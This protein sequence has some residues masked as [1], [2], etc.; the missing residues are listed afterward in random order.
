MNETLRPSTLGEILDRTA[1]LYRRNF[2]LFAGTAALPV[3]AMLAIGVVAGALFAAVA[4]V[5]RG[6]SLPSAMA[7][8]TLLV[9]LAAI[10]PVYVAAGVF[11]YAGLTQ[12]AVSTHRGE[13]PTIRQTLATVR[14]RFWRY[15]GFILLEGIL[16]ILVPL[17]I[18]GG[19][20]GL[21]VYLASN[22]GLGGASALGFLAVLIG[23]VGM[24]VIIWCA[25][26]CSMGFAAC[27]V[28]QKTA[29]ESL[30]RSWNLG[31]GSRGRI[32]VLYLLVMALQL[33]GSM[34][35]YILSAIIMGIAALIGN[36]AQYS[37]ILAAVAGLLQIIVSFGLQVLLTPVSWIALVLF[38]YDQRIRKEGFDI[39]WMMEQAGLV[40]PAPVAATSGVLG[41]SAPAQSASGAAPFASAD[42]NGGTSG[43]VAPP[44]TVPPDT[45]KER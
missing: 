31:R 39:E 20:V 14:P 40:A 15:F 12:A 19:V 24:F 6:E 37:A 38:Y 35:G 21:L 32:F 28:E 42:P 27:V 43:P 33:A 29:W 17:V 8:V 22:A 25:L 3:G 11:S 30:Q 26:G 10:L 18:F 41:L 5:F 44:D 2:L 9:A 13:R 36:G 7:G 23:A 16:V 45:V 4:V 1:Q 34:A